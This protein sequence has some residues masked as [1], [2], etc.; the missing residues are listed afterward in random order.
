[1]FS[2]ILQNFYKQFCLILLV[3]VSVIGLI[4]VLI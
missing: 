1:L 4:R 2:P 3:F